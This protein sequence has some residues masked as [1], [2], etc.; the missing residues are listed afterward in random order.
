MF[1]GSDSPAVAVEIDDGRA[2]WFILDYSAL[3]GPDQLA[4]TPIPEDW[5]ALPSV[6]VRS[7][8]VRRG[9]TR[10][11]QAMQAGEAIVV[12]DNLSGDYDPDNADSTYVRSGYSLLSRGQPFRVRAL[13]SV[14][15][16]DPDVDYDDLLVDYDSFEDQAVTLLRGFIEGVTPDQG[17]DATVTITATDALAWLGNQPVAEIAAAHSGDDTSV[18]AAR[19]L[20]AVGWS[21]TDRDLT[22]SREMQPT[23]FGRSALDLLDECATCE[24]GVLFVTRDGVVKL[25]PY[26]EMYLGDEVAAFSDQRTDRTV[27]YDAISTS[28]GAEYLTNSV[29]WTTTTGTEVTATDAVSVSRFGEHPARPATVPLLST[30]AAEDLA[31]LVAAQ[32]AF[33]LT[34]VT[35]LEFDAVGLGDA[36]PDVLGAELRDRATVDRTTPD[37][38]ALT[39][40][41][42]IESMNHDITPARWRVSWA[43]APAASGTR[44]RLDFSTLDGPDNI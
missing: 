40:I 5:I 12:L 41:C 23:T 28:P 6:D 18:R 27:E 22:G 39:Y 35:R 26:E 9:R 31:A 32:Y 43:L 25:V 36:W 38:R 19:I 20:D 13:S 33:P 16:D 8:T 11:D 7:I 44:F 10:E 2:G 17:F 14:S 4:P 3:D 30:G 15:Y 21:A 37:G 29:T 1:D 34:R 42:A 24:A